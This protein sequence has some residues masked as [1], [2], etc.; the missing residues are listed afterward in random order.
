MV[1]SKMGM[2]NGIISERVLVKRNSRVV[3]N[4]VGEFVS[5]EVSEDEAEE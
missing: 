3:K 5:G 1:V 2:S 4:K